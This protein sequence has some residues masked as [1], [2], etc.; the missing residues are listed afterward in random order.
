MHNL[1][2]DPAYADVVVEL[3]AELEKLREQYEV[4]PEDDDYVVVRPE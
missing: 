4:P 1:Y 2:D 3:K